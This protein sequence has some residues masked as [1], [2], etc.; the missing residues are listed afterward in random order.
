MS[1]RLRRL[2]LCQHYA[3][4]SKARAY[5]HILLKFTPI[6]RRSW[7]CQCSTFFV[8]RKLCSFHYSFLLFRHDCC[9]VI[10]SKSFTEW[11]SLTTCSEHAEEKGATSS[12]SSEYSS[13]SI[14]RKDSLKMMAAID[15]SAKVRKVR[16][17][18]LPS[19]LRPRPLIHCFVR[20]N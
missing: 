17:A 2:G 19:S 18:P 11:M 14:R 10:P 4:P 9:C 12:D 8:G 16:G 1:V 3:I 5:P 15:A 20:L 6:R 7:R 13:T